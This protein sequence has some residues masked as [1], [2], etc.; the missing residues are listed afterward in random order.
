MYLSQQS[1][2]VYSVIKDTWGQRCDV[3]KFFIDPIVETAAGDYV[4]LRE[5]GMSG[6]VK[7]PTDVVVVKEMKRPWNACVGQGDGTCRN[8]WEVSPR[9]CCLSGALL[10]SS[11]ALTCI[12]ENLQKVKLL[13]VEYCV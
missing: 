3:L 11:S 13:W 12:I 2:E 1:N 10:N 6:V 9:L 4:D 5:E 7:V 8:I